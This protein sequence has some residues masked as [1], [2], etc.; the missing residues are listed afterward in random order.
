MADAGIDAWHWKYVFDLWRPVVGIRAEA[1]EV[2]D[3]FWAPYGAPQTNQPGKVSR[4]PGFPAYPSGHATFGAATMQVLRLA[5]G[6]T[7]MTVQEVIDA[8]NAS[9]AVAGEAFSFVSDELNGM[10][11]DPDGSRRALCPRAFTS[12]ARPVW[13]NAISRVFLGVHWRFDGMPRNAA[14]NVGG[15]PLGLTIGAQVH[16]FFENGP[17]L[18]KP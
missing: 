12:F 3:G 2:R 4:T 15:V 17:S 16:A 13:E 5:R 9:A 18:G 14:D 8:G 10:H 7:A 1:Q 6:G 11:D